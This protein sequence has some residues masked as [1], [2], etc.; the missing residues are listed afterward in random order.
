MHVYMAG[1]YQA[2]IN[3]TITGRPSFLIRPEY[4][5]E[6]Y[7][8]IDGNPR[9]ERA[10]REGK[11]TIFLDSGAFSAFTQG[12]SINIER[13]AAYIKRNADFVHMAANLDV[14]GG[15][16]QQTYDNQKRLEDMGVEVV[17]VHHARDRDE[18]LVRYIQEGYEY[19]AL[20]GM[21]PE[22]TPYLLEWL[23]HV[24]G[25]YL[26]DDAGR[27]VV[28]V[29]GFGLTS[30]RLMTRYPWTSVDSTSWVLTSRFGQIYLD[31]DDDTIIK[32]DFSDRSSKK[33]E[34]DSW[35]WLSL[36]K[37]EQEK[38]NTRLAHLEKI[39]VKYP[40][41]EQQL[42]KATGWSQGWNAQCFSKQYGWRDNFNIAFFERMGRHSLQQF[43]IK[44]ETLFT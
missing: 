18:W 26:T 35:H 14:I 23:D 3:T 31:L 19:I 43:Q 36:T 17:P 4:L 10:L 40:E 24:W 39:R 8:Y 15:S 32:V 6:S 28:K 33:R 38:I 20:G 5:L 16:E 22:S 42:E 34:I 29:H 25:K 9:T 1:F 37:H 27:P 41:I 7:H 2:R 44:Q 12:A 21:V 30:N 11:Q 13:Y